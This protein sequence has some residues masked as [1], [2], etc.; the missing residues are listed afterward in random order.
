MPKIK[1]VIIEFDDDTKEEIWIISDK[2]KRGGE[3]NESK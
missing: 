1:R 3:N 2:I